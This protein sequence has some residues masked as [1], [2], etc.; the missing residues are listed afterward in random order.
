MSF[1]KC[2]KCQEELDPPT[3]QEDMIHGWHCSKGHR[4]PRKYTVEQWI[5]IVYNGLVEL[6]EMSEEGNG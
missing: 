4:Q 5:C 6:Q 3:P 1:A 2:W